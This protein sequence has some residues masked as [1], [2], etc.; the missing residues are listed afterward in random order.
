MY[1]VRYIRLNYL[2]PFLTITFE[3]SD[4]HESTYDIAEL[5]VQQFSTSNDKIAEPNLL[6]WDK[7]QILES[8]YARVPLDKYLADESVAKSVVKSLVKYGVAFIEDVEATVLGT[9]AA[10]KRLFAVQKTFFG[11]MWSF[12]DDKDHSDT[13]YSKSY[14]GAHTDNT[15]FNDAAGLQV[16]HCIQ[17]SGTGGENLLLDGFRA[18][19]DLKAKHPST[20]DRLCRTL[21]PAEYIEPKQHHTYSAPIIRLDAITGQPEQI[22][23][24]LFDRKLNVNIFKFVDLRFNLYDRSVMRTLPQTEMLQFY[25]DLRLLTAEIQTSANEWWFKLKPGTVVMFNNWRLLHGRA[26]YTGRRKM[27]GCY[28]SRT[29]FLSVARTM[30][31]ID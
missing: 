11:E 31:I 15:Y 25:K 10:V 1:H 27:A 3:G 26:A 23:Y 4:N 6:L 13:A 18:I 5:S 20:Y 30:A 12:S 28:V 29:E 17:Y 9:E 16:L 19:A 21:V 8:S 7:A 24:V 22:R 2:I 14:L